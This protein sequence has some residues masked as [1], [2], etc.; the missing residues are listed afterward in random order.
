M[1][2]WIDQVV[3]EFGETKTVVEAQGEA[4]ASEGGSNSSD[5]PELALPSVPGRLTPSGRTLIG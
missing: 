4:M 2:M 3:K 1:E 5:R